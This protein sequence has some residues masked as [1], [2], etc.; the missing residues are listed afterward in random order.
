MKIFDPELQLINTKPLIKNKF[1][2]LLSQFIK[3]HV[4]TVLVLDYKKRNECKISHSSVKLI[5]KDSDTDEA[6]ISMYQSIMKKIN[7]DA[8]EDWIVLDLI[9]KHSIK[10]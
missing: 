8:S 9:I 7:N 5:G 3:C 6:Y 10:T 1:K 4:Q 2:E